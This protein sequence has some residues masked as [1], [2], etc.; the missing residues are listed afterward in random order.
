MPLAAIRDARCA[1]RSGRELRHVP[2]PRGRR[3]ARSTDSRANTNSAP[4]GSGSSRQ[5]A[6]ASASS[7]AAAAASASGRSRPRC[8]PCARG[9]RLRDSSA[10]MAVCRPDR[11]PRARLARHRGNP[12][13]RPLVLCRR[14][15]RSWTSTASWPASSTGRSRGAETPEAG[16]RHDPRA[17]LRDGRGRH[18]RPARRGARGA[19]H[20]GRARSAGR[21]RLRGQLADAYRACLWS[22][23]GLRVLWQLARF[24][25]AD[26]RSA[27]RGRARHRLERAPRV[28]GTLAVDF[29]GT[30]AGHHAHAVRRAASQGRDRRPVPRADR[31]AARPSTRVARRCASTCM[32]RAARVTLAIDLAGESLHRRG[33]RGGQG[34]APL[35]ENLAAAILLRAGWPALAAAGGVASST[36]CAAPARWRSRRR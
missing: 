11:H 29:S 20:R 21:R 32:S 13:L 31:R 26:A 10:A 9:S 30:R 16:R 28:D 2:P 3:S 5:R 35:K 15:V 19:R 4:S 18:G 12:R 8:T 23:L 6:P 27:L 22:R 1:R 36:R 34:A 7:S 14:A 24:P 17:I 33:Y 25:V